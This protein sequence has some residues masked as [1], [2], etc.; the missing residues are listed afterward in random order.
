MEEFEKKLL[1]QISGLKE[2]PT[3]KNVA[4]NI[5]F[6]GQSFARNSTP[7]VSIVPKTDKAG[8]DIY[9]QDNVKGKEVHIP[10]IVSADNLNDLVYNDFHIG[11]NADVVIM[12][13]CGIHSNCESKSSHNGIHAFY[14]GEGSKVKY[15]ENH[16]GTGEE[17]AIR[18]LNPQ[19]VIKQG[20]NSKMEIITT[21]LGGVSSSIRTTKATLGENASLIIKERILTTESQTAKTD[22]KVWLKG[23]GSRTDVVSRAVAKDDSV[24]TFKSAVIGL[25]QCFGHVECDAILCDKAVISSLPSVIAKNTDAILTHEAAIGKISEEQQRKLMTLGLTS[26]EAEATIINGFLD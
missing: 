12:A 17:K 8:I 10:V 20:K 24:Q 2:I 4:F 25:N 6:N 11:K 3:G 18:I 21:Q 5:R 9:V 15:I 22:F 1:E 26:E 7:E 13:G 16:L 23:K 14:L 19:T